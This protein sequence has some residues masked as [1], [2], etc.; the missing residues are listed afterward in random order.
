MKNVLAE[1][2]EYAEETQ[3]GQTDFEPS[4]FSLRSLREKAFLGVP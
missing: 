2:A 3:A 1:Y 4:W